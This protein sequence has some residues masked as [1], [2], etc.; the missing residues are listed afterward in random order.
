MLKRLNITVTCCVTHTYPYFCTLSCNL[1]SCVK[2]VLCNHQRATD[3]YCKS[4]EPVTAN[5]LPV[6]NII[7]KQ[8]NYDYNIKPRIKLI[9]KM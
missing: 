4:V 6:L 5:Q 9:Y 2:I 1:V 3:C 7:Y 8:L